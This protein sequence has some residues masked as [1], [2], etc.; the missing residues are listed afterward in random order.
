MHKKNIFIT[1]IALFAYLF[2]FAQQAEKPLSDA[3]KK[4][5]KTWKLT[6]VE[7]FHQTLPPS[8]VQKNDETTFLNDRT[9][10]LMWEGK[11]YTGTWSLDKSGKW[12]TVVV[13]ATEKYKFQILSAT[14]EKLVYQYQSEELIRTNYTF[15]EKKK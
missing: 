7:A 11:S 5:C 13:S 14:P 9:A 10:F 8:D 6:A 4:L 1:V 3:E 15:E 2:N 12:I